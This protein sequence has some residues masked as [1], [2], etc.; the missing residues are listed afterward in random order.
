MRSIRRNEFLWPAAELA[1]AGSHCQVA[2]LANPTA[3]DNQ[4]EN[5]SHLD[6]R[7]VRAATQGGDAAWAHCVMTPMLS[8]CRAWGRW[9]VHGRDR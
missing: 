8:I 9:P 3:R 4:D 1:L 7:T 6:C 5:A 2:A